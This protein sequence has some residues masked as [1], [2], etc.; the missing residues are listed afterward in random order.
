MVSAR[1]RRERGIKAIGREIEAV[2]ER[3]LS[4]NSG[5]HGACVDVDDLSCYRNFLDSL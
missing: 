4:D 2:Q 5:G 1:I 3:V